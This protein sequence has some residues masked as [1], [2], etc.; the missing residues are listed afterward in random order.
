[1]KTTERLRSTVGI[2]CGVLAFG[3]ALNMA[4]GLPLFRECQSVN[5][6]W[7]ITCRANTSSQGGACVGVCWDFIVLPEGMVCDRCYTGVWICTELE[8]EYGCGTVVAVVGN[9]ATPQEGGQCGCTWPVP[10]V[11]ANVY[12]TGNC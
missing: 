12:A 1:M 7:I 3:V 2:L 9:C 8:Q 5:G 4:G 10:P 6:Q 11:F